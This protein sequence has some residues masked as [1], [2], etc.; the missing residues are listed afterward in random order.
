GRGNGANLRDRDSQSGGRT[1]WRHPAAI[2]NR[3]FAAL[4]DRRRIW[5]SAGLVVDNVGACCDADAHGGPGLGRYHRGRRDRAGRL[6]L[7]RLSGATRREA[8]PDSCVEVGTMTWFELGSAV[9][10][11]LA[12]VR[13]HKT[14]SLLTVLGV[15]I[16]TGTVIAVGSIITGV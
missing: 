13:E 8:R 1:T 10:M 6:V 12:T 14:R 3:V 2:F 9:C 11:A 16:G 15:V 5:R 4:G 7:R